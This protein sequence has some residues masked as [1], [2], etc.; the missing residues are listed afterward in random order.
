MLKQRDDVHRKK[1]RQN[2]A[3]HTVQ[4]CSP[5]WIKIHLNVFNEIHSV[6]RTHLSPLLHTASLFRHDRL[7]KV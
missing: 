3:K 5:S 7:K 1:N 2:T 6:N 4:R